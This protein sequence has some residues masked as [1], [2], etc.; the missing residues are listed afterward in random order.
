MNEGMGNGETPFEKKWACAVTLNPNFL[1]D[2]FLKEFENW[3]KT[4]TSQY[5]IVTEK[6]DSKRHIHCTMLLQKWREKTKG[7]RLDRVK[8]SLWKFQQKHD[9]SVT[10]ESKN[11]TYGGV[12]IIY[13]YDW[14]NK[15]MKKNDDTVEIAKHTPDKYDDYLP[16][17]EE[18]LEAIRKAEEKKNA[19]VKDQFFNKLATLWDENNYTFS[20]CNGLYLLEKKA[21]A[22][23]LCDMMY[24]KKLISVIRDAKCRKNIINA[25]P[26]YYLCKAEWEQDFTKDEL[27]QI[28]QIED[29]KLG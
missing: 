4:H 25:F 15:Y 27:D 24:K 11:V 14:E 16:T 12:R 19:L 22:I 20:E 23:F 10:P 21:T 13:N 9:E 26:Q 6:K 1:S 29:F 18:Q 8:E 28:N 17:A 7:R 3:V 5:S 2:E